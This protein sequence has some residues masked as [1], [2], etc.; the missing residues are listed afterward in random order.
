MSSEPVPFD[1]KA[2][3]AAH[4]EW[5]D[6]RTT[7]P[8]SQ[9]TRVQKRYFLEPWFTTFW[10]ISWAFALLAYI[11]GLWAG[12][13]IEVLGAIFTVVGAAFAIAK[14]LHYEANVASEGS[15]QPKPE[16]RPYWD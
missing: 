12:W 7:P 6:N 11:V 8:L 9:L 4:Q 3:E 14:G 10:V 1:R 5:L 2:R 13:R 15:V 16:R